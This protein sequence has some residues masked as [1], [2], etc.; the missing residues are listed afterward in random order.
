MK[1]LWGHQSPVDMSN[2]FGKSQEHLWFNGGKN[3]F[4]RDIKK[5]TI[6]EPLKFRER[7]IRYEE[8]LGESYMD[9]SL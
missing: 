8:F 7:S 6:D 5:S 1:F 2:V 4:S 3:V 9:I